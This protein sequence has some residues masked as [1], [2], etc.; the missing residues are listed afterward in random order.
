MAAIRELAH[1]VSHFGVQSFT[2]AESLR[3]TDTFNYCPP[4]SWDPAINLYEADK[5]YLLCMDLAGMN[6]RE[7]DVQVKNRRLSIRGQRRSPFPNPRNSFSVH[8]MEIDHGE[9]CRT[10]ELPG[11]INAD[12]I[13]AKYKNGWLWVRM[14]KT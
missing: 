5:E 3:S 13:T 9:F 1:S 8:L 7:I 14:P 2:A 11:S 12:T 10:I 4:D 6:E